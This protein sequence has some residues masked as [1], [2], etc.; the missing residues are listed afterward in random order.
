MKKAQAKKPRHWRKD[1]LSKLPEG[2]E[3][4]WRKPELAAYLGVSVS[5]IDKMLMRGVAPPGFRVGNL[6]RWWP[7][8]V[9]KWTE[10]GGHSQ[11]IGN[12]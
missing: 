4:P 5:A 9:R 10:E 1:T 6:W 12:A 11:Q 7:S 3:T 8:A 2:I